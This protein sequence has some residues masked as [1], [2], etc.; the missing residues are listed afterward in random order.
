MHSPVLSLTPPRL[1]KDGGWPPLRG[2][3][4]FQEG[5]MRVIYEEGVHETPHGKVHVRMDWTDDRLDAAIEPQERRR[6][7]EDEGCA[8]EGDAG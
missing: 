4:G 3:L 7:G 5:A 6:D 8:Q 2:A 1:G